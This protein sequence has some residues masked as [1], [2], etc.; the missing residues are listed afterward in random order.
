[1][2]AAMPT[3]RHVNRAS[4]KVRLRRQCLPVGAGGG[5]GGFAHPFGDGFGLAALDAG[6]FELAGRG[7]RVEGG[8]GHW[9]SKCTTKPAMASCV[10]MSAAA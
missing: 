7:E 8:G 9:L 4:S 10:P 5:I 1:M 6:R 2:A 3:R